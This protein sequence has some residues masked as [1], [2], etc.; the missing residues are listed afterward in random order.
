MKPQ[1]KRVIER[2]REHDKIYLNTFPQK[3]KNE[4]VFSLRDKFE[5]HILDGSSV[6][7]CR[8][9][10]QTVV[11]EFEKLR[12]HVWFCQIPRKQQP[13]KPITYEVTFMDDII[14]D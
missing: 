12:D 3:T 5:R 9:C 8:T 4:S 10:N 14:N 13:K 1:L 2:T 11:D 7:R 6:V